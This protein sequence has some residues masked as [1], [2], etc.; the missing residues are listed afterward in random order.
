MRKH[1]THTAQ[2]CSCLEPQAS[3]QCVSFKSGCEGE[4]WRRWGPES[5][6]V[7][8]Y[9][10]CWLCHPLAVWPWKSFL[11]SLC[12]RFA[13]LKTLRKWLAVSSY[14]CGEFIDVK[15]PFRMLHWVAFNNGIN[16]NHSNSCND[17]V[18]FIYLVAFLGYFLLKAGYW[19]IW[20][21]WRMWR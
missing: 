13:P 9:A 5:Q 3:K 2:S 7:N 6:K 14:G 21:K 8:V 10:L 19:S 17:I 1:V 11:L 20:G 18:A 16:R 15:T 12:L 4:K